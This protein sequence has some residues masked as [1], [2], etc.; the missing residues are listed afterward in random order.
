MRTFGKILGIA[1]L[2][3]LVLLAGGITATIGW[4]PFIGP[5]SRPLTD[6][7]FEATPERL[8]RGTYI[9]EHLS[10]CMDCHTPFE[11][12]GNNAPRP[13]GSGQVFPLP[14]FPGTLVAANLT[15]DLETGIGKWTDDEIARAVREGVDRNGHT[16]FPLMPYPHFKH[17]SDEDI[18]SVVVYLRA[19]TPVRN[20]LPVSVVNFPLK[21]L[22]QGVPEPVTE[23]VH[24]DFSTPVSR[25]KYLVDVAACADCHTPHKRGQGIPGM[26]LAGGRVFDEPDGKIVS[27]NITPDPTGIGHY[28]EDTFLK[29]LR[30]GYVGTRA[31]NTLMPWQFYSGL[32]EEDLKAMYAYLKTVQPVAHRVDNHKAFTVCKKCGATHGAG[33]EN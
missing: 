17:M 23:P 24:S 16:L 20:P 15:S 27:A 18:A 26:Y 10:G 1:V 11:T 32:T 22:I 33:N 2:V 25:G 13:K 7:N 21:Y 5:R 19:L 14:G 9:T 3:L 30:T 29:A 28:S 6:R 4:R 31:L 8:T 12:P